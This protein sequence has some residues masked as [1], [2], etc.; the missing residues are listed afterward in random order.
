MSTHILN[1][2]QLPTGKLTCAIVGERYRPQLELPLHTRGISVLW[3]P[4]NPDIDERL[5]GHVDLSV[6]PLSNHQVLLAPYLKK[7]PLFVNKLTNRGIS[8]VYSRRNQRKTYPGDANLNVCHFG[9]TAILNPKTADPYILKQLRSC[10]FIS[11]KQG[12]TNCT[13][14]PV[15]DASIITDDAGIAKAANCAG[16]EVL[17]IRSGFVD[18]P[19]FATGFLGGASQMFTKNTMMFTGVLTN[20]PD[21]EIIFQFLGQRKIKPDF[22]TD[23]PVFDIGAIYGI[24][25][26]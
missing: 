15:D 1:Q 10:N 23:F 3:L 7:H 6:F 2:I 8:I 20:H 4:D 21:A 25:E 12:Y 17:Q 19:G 18:L 5:A 24:L 13:V 22:L 14:V 11:V 26:E 9:R 16:L